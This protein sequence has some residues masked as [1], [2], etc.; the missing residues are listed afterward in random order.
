MSIYTKLNELSNDVSTLSVRTTNIE[1][2]SYTSLTNVT[3]SN[4][5]VNTQLSGATV[6]ANVLT[7]SN[8]SASAGLANILTAS[9]FSASSGL[10]NL[11]TLTASNINVTNEIFSVTLSSTN[12]ETEDIIINNSLDAGPLSYDALQGNFILDNAALELISGAHIY[13]DAQSYAYLNNLQLIN[14]ASPPAVIN[15]AI[16]NITGSLYFGSASVWRKITV[17]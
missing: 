15:G 10:A 1:N 13:G 8:F 4:I 17:T 3:A 11:T 12:L 9:N 5:K 14:N 2:G 7:A 6:F 16:I